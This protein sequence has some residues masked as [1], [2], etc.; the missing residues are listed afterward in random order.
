MCVLGG[1]GE[2]AAALTFR[3]THTKELAGD[4]ISIAFRIPKAQPGK[5]PPMLS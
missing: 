1:Y 5:L 3:Y 2:H 4:N